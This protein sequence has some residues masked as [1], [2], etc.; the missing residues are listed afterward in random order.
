MQKNEVTSL[1]AQQLL[2]KVVVRSV[3]RHVRHSPRTWNPK[4][5]RRNSSR[6]SRCYKYPTMV[7]PWKSSYYFATLLNNNCLF[8]VTIAYSSKCVCKQI[9]L[10]L[11]NSWFYY[12][13]RRFRLDMYTFFGQI[14]LLP[15]YFSVLP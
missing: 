2:P 13:P 10:F 11:Q 12:F 4:P 15:T 14:L 3:H 9:N 6:F 8:A 1:N 5:T 7:G